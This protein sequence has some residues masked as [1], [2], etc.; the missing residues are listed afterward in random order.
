MHA[1]T[2]VPT[3]IDYAHRM[4][5]IAAEMAGFSLS[6]LED[7]TIDRDQAKTALYRNFVQKGFQAVAVLGPALVDL[8]V[9]EAEK[10]PLPVRAEGGEKG[11]HA[12]TTVRLWRGLTIESLAVQAGL[13]PDL[14]RA[15]EARELVANEMH[16]AAMA[17]VLDVSPHALTDYG[18]MAVDRHAW[19]ADTLADLAACE[20]D[21]GDGAS[22]T[23]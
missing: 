11:W 19:L 14:I 1:F 3:H 16:D 18:A 5:E 20:K 4:A 6:E 10:V 2:K 23:Q 9:K 22:D 8:D 12:L 13:S 7:R 21:G 15:I 17:A